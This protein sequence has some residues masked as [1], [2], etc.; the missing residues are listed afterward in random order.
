MNNSLTWGDHVDMLIKKLNSRL[1]CLRKMC[2][3]NV[4][5]EILLTFFN[6]TLCSVWRYC[7]VCWGG[8]VCAIEASRINRIIRKASRMIGEPQPN[9]EIIYQSLLQAKTDSITD[10]DTHPL[11]VLFVES[12]MES[13]RLRLPN[14]KT[15]RYLNSFVP[16]AIKYINSKFV[17]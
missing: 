16:R 15:N 12:Q 6:S 5:S 10:D 9:C 4:R 17:R 11:H 7:F 13:G 14:L 1:Y 3:I 8:N 2:N